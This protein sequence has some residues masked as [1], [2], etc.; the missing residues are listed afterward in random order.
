M[1]APIGQGWRIMRALNL[2][3]ARWHQLTVSL[4]TVF[5]FFGGKMQLFRIF[6][7]DF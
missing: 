2:H 1:R 4:F 7:L 6:K 3:K 5:F